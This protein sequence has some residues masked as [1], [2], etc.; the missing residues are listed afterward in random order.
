MLVED[1]E[2]WGVGVGVG[3]GVDVVGGMGGGV[4]A[5]DIVV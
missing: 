1:G 3:V 2:D 4:L 5:A